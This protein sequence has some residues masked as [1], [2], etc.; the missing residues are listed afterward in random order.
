MLCSAHLLSAAL[1]QKPQNEYDTHHQRGRHFFL[2]IITMGRD[3]RTGG[4]RR[5][6]LNLCTYPRP[7]PNYRTSLA[8][9]LLPS[10]SV[11]RSLCFAP[12][13]AAPIFI[14]SF[15]LSFAAG[16][17]RDSL[18]DSAD[19]AD[20]ASPP[21][22][23]PA[24][25]TS[26]VV[27]VVVDRLPTAELQVLRLRRM[28]ERANGLHDTLSQPLPRRRRR[29]RRSGINSL[30]PRWCAEARFGAVA[31][32]MY[33]LALAGYLGGRQGRREGGRKGGR[34]EDVLLLPRLCTALNSPL[35]LLLPFDSLQ[36]VLLFFSCPS[37]AAS[38]PW[39]RRSPSP[40][41]ARLHILPIYP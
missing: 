35:C 11:V 10:S 14:I 33:Y 2:R 29:R 30:C 12:D 19:S 40:A 38:V 26:V 13:F 20:A 37:V 36:Y 18:P 28:N 15:L 23:Q 32:L 25:T 5:G 9:R 27:V 6:G 16:K 21:S 34:E 31:R 3:E 4:H 17:S 24:V 1:R 41:P 22:S 7:N 8:S 39:S